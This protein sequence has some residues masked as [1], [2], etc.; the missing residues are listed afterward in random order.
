MLKFEE[1]TQK[2]Y[3]FI[4]NNNITKLTSDPTKKYTLELNKT[5]NKCTQLF[6][7]RTQSSL[8][9][10][11]ASAPCLRGLPKIHKQ[12]TP[13]RPLVNFTT[14]PGYKIA[15]TLVKIIKEHTNCLLYTSRCV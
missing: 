11:N 12:N 10:I 1:Y 8:K 9:P 15:K 6:D 2:V 7:K 3:N 5:I 4:N 14:A 13:I